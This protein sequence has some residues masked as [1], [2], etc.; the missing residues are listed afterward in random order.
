MARLQKADCDMAKGAWCGQFD[1]LQL[2]SQTS[3][4]CLVCKM[5]FVYAPQKAS[6]VTVPCRRLGAGVPNLLPAGVL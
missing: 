2:W 1:L 3:V 6:V 5:T 4:R